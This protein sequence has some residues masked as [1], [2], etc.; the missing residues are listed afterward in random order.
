MMRVAR[1]TCD[2][3]Q[4]GISPKIRGVGG[5]LSRPREAVWGPQGRRG[6]DC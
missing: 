3:G 4:A 6:V 2:N 1:E 5:V